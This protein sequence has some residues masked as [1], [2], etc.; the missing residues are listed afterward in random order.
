MKQVFLLVFFCFF[1]QQDN[2][3]AQI[4]VVNYTVSNDDFVNP[5]RGFYRY[6]A[7][8]SANYSFLDSATIA[9]YR[10]L[11]SPFSADY[12]I[13]SSLVYRY[14]FLEDF[15]SGPISQTYLDNVALDFATARSAGVKLVV[16]FAYTEEVDPNGCD[17]WICPPYGDA[18]KNV[19]L[20][21]IAQL[22]EVINANA[23]VIMAVQMGFIGVWGENYYTDYFGDA[24]QAPYNLLPNEWTDRVEVLNA[25]LSMVPNSR[26]VQ[27]RY[28]QM[29]Q[30]AVYGIS[31]P[32]TSAPLTA[33]EAHDGSNKSRIGFHND[34]FLANYDDYGTYA[35]YDD[36]SSD[37]T[38]LKPYKAAD[39]KYVVVGGETCN[40]YSGSYC[41]SE[42]GMADYDLER[43]HYTYLNADYNN[44]VNNEW[45]GS[46]MDDIKLRLGYRLVLLNGEYSTMLIP[47]GK[48]YYAIEIEN[49]GYSA[50]V[51]ERLVELILVEAT[52]NVEWKVTLPHDPRDWHTGVHTF[53]GEI[54]VPDCIPSGN[55]DLRLA[56]TDP[57]P[58]LR[59]RKEYAIRLANTNVWESTTGYNDLLHT[60]PISSTSGTCE[61]DL[62]F[63]TT[64]LVNEWISPSDGNWYSSTGNWSLGKFPDYCEEVIIPENRVVSMLDGETGNAKKVTLRSNSRLEVASTG[65]ITL[66]K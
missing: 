55:Y 47:G 25:L 24:S 60:M 63:E 8:S 6:S 58:L 13:Y 18:P 34:C 23:D 4:S 19:V 12:S 48:F 59:N 64:D 21:H 53:A 29:K 30:K 28:P 9:G 49:I 10:V 35:N 66:R 42:G 44:A 38:N 11:H 54:C 51:N 1:L 46:C 32:T 7:T 27:V 56:L 15:K 2:I 22:E 14:F 39:S 65:S 37:T 50:P 43:M 3:I 45:V 33:A 16:R 62:I 61:L 31:A 17:S 5:E 40:L 26:Q 41:E 57:M 52:T 36:G 20:D